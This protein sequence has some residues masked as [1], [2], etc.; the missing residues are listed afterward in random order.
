MIDLEYLANNLEAYKQNLAN[1]QLRVEDF[2]L[3]KIV[4]LY[5][6]QKKISREVQELQRQRNLLTGRVEEREKA[7][8][9]KADLQEREGTL[10]EIEGTLNKFS[11]DLP[12]IA[13][14]DVPEGK[15]EKDNVVI[16]E[17]GEKPKFGFTPKDHLEI[18]ESLDIIDIKRAKD[19][20]GTRFAYLKGDV[21]L[22]EFALVDLA[23]KTAMKEGFIPVIP[24]ALIKPGVTEGLGY[25]LQNFYLVGDPRCPQCNHDLNI[26][27]DTKGEYIGG[28]FECVECDSRKI[29]QEVTHDGRLKC[30]NC[31]GET[32][33]PYF[34]LVGTAEHSIAPMHTN[35]RFEGEKLPRRY[36]GFSSAFRREAGTYGKD[37][38]GILRV[39][40][41]D[42]VE[43]FSYCHPKRSRE[44]HQFLVSLQE[45]LW[46]A[47]EIPYRVVQLCTGDM[48]HPSASTI[49]IEAWM[50][51]EGIYREVSSA[52]NTTDFQARRMKI[53]FRE[54]GGK[55][56]FV[57][58]LNATAFAIGRTLIAILENYQQKDG[59]V[60]IPKVLQ[61]YV[62][63]D[64]I[65]SGSN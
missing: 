63:K 52:S 48:S 30:H 20:S 42:K 32:R 38:R 36:I 51:G 50:P 55:V 53:R 54:K 11:W 31:R 18:G 37:T 47:L 22:L 57:H 13:L 16:K 60:F 7:K 15:D 6:N 58:M 49:D 3:E 10:R 29:Y 1:R 39:H 2:Q 26:K 21:V 9:L 17:V 8:K 12:N 44:E 24:P 61:S 46:Q 4:T 40:Q 35:E 23:M 19:V 62:G 33:L 25:E 59:S 41:F 27:V 28:E 65:K 43:L 56:D 14:G 5:D 34:Y 64:R 45:K